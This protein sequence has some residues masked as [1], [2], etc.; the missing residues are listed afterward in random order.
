MRR[1]TPVLASAAL[2][3]ACVWAEPARADVLITRAEAAQPSPVTLGSNTRGL[4]RG[5]GI[6]QVS[7]D[8]DR[9]VASPVPLRIKFVI[10]NN[11]AIDP[12]SIKLT[13]LK[14]NPIDLTERIRKH[15][16]PEGI[17][18]ERAE[19]PPGKHSM[20][21]EVTDKQGRSNSAII[22]LTVAGR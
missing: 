20:R 1:T 5:P 18:M 14:A 13:Y 9:D 8:P 6:E 7:P 10:R 15:L 17:V 4:T 3:L 11:V 12:A 16:T 22:K 19:V 2:V 21:L